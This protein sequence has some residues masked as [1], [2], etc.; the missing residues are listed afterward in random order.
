MVSPSVLYDELE[1]ISMSLA[2]AEDTLEL[3]CSELLHSPHIHSNL[4]ALSP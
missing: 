3:P 4:S 1:L 2:V